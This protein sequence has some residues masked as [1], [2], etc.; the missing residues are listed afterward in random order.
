MKPTQFPPGTGPFRF[1]EWLPA[2]RVVFQRFENHWGHKTYVDRLVIRPIADTTVRFTAL[3]AGDVDSVERTPYE[4]MKHSG[5]RSESSGP[6]GISKSS[7][8]GN[9]R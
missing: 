2:Q 3:Q 6:M 4:R 9:V 1:V 5:W 7:I 8:G